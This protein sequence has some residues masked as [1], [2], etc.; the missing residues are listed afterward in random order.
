MKIILILTATLLLVGCSMEQ[1]IAVPRAG[2]NLIGNTTS[3]IWHLL[4]G[5]I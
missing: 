5:W 3:A 2:V 1:V 4:T